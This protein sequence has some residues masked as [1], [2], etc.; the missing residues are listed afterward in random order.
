MLLYLEAAAE[1]LPL[2]SH[3]KLVCTLTVSFSKMLTFELQTKIEM[4]ENSHVTC[5]CGKVS[6]SHKRA[7]MKL[8]L[9][10]F[11]SK[12]YFMRVLM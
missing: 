5:V 8:F 12:S 9:T 11:F 2:S 4:Y 1:L 6:V 3:H 10:F 7:I